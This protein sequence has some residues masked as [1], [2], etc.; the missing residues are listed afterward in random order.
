MRKYVAIAGGVA[1]AGLAAAP[2]TAATIYA[3]D[4]AREYRRMYRALERS[5][6]A[7]RTQ[8]TR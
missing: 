2:L 4:L 8:G 1:I 7:M 6:H 3:Y 5:L